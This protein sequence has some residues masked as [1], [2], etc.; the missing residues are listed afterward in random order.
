MKHINYLLL[1]R[2]RTPSKCSLIPCCAHPGRSTN[3]RVITKQDRLCHVIHATS[4]PFYMQWL[5]HL[6]V[7]HHSKVLTIGDCTKEEINEYYHDRLIQDVP[8]DL[9]KNLNFDEIHSYFGGK[10]AHWS[11]YLTEYTNQNGNLTRTLHSSFFLT[12]SRSIHPIPSSIHV[13]SSASLTLALSKVL[14]RPIS[15]VSISLRRKQFLR[16]SP[17]LCSCPSPHA[18]A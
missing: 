18:H 13:P 10:L 1:S 4:D 6:N 7:G 15:R 5:R 8:S 3:D 9:R 11:D 17:I 14:T 12:L 16:R 2:M